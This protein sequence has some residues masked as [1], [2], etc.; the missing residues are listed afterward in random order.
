MEGSSR[1]VLMNT[2]WIMAE[3]VRNKR[4]I[5]KQI[6]CIQALPVVSFPSNKKIWHNTLQALRSYKGILSAVAFSFWISNLISSNLV[7]VRGKELGIYLWKTEQAQSIL[8]P[9]AKNEIVFVP[10]FCTL[11]L[12]ACAF[13]D[14]QWSSIVHH[15]WQKKVVSRKSNRPLGMCLSAI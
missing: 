3:N 10:P 12:N 1:N 9:E 6:V 4:W 13:E 11:D 8:L 7:E 15:R 5:N 2:Y 14:Q